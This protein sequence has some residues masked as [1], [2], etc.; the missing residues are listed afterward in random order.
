MQRAAARPE[1]AERW[2]WASALR[3]NEVGPV[4]WQLPICHV[5][6]TC[7]EVGL[8]LH[9]LACFHVMTRPV[10]PCAYAYFIERIMHYMRLRVLAFVKQVITVILILFY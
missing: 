3:V 6:F 9:G 10:A 7:G 8:T 5:A 2:S 1:A 4:P